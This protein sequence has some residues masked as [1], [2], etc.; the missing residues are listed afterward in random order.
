[1]GKGWK[2]KLPEV[3]VGWPGA[4]GL[5]G[6]VGSGE[7]GMAAGVGVTAMGLGL[8]CLGLSGEAGLAV[9]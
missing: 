2:K 8:A 1:M 4:A 3:G 6:W 9:G 7:E 5:A